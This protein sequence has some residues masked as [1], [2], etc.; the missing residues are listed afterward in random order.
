MA[1][2]QRAPRF[3]VERFSVVYDT[4]E[5]FWC[6][7]V[8]DVSESGL[9][10]ETAHELPVGTAVTILPDVPDENALPFEIH[11]EV[12][13]VHQLNLEE[14][15]DRIPGLAFRWCDLTPEQ[16]AQVR[17]FIE[18]HGTSTR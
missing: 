6:G 4:G 1:G 8:I 9:F 16:V 17:R 11:G 18:R 3:S 7:P 12:V 14:H 2:Q 10:V 5:G 15:A 13:R